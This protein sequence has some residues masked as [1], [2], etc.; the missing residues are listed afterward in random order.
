MSSDDLPPAGAT[1]ANQRSRMVSASLRVG[2]PANRAGRLPEQADPLRECQIDL[3]VDD[4]RAYEYNPRRADNAKFGEIKESIRESGI[5]NPISVTRRPG[6]DHFIVE[7]G[8]NTR[9]LAVQQLWTETRELRFRKLSVLFRPWR[10]E[11]HVLVSHL[12]ENELRGSMTFWDRANGIAALKVQLEVEQGCEL[13]LRQLEAELKQVGIAVSHTTLNYY[14]FTTGRLR[15]LAE[16]VTDLTGLDVI[17]IQPRLNQIK[18]YAQAQAAL[19]EDELYADVLQPVFRRHADTFVQT[20]NFQPEALCRDCEEALALRLN[21]PLMKCRKALDALAAPASDEVAAQDDAADS[22]TDCT[23]EGQT[24]GPIPD[25]NEPR[26]GDTAGSES[27]P[28]TKK[29]EPAA[30]NSIYKDVTS[31]K[32]PA[33]NTIYSE[34]CVGVP[35]KY[36]LP[37]NP[38]ATG[39]DEPG[40]DRRS[41]IVGIERFARLAGVGDCL[42]AAP[43]TPLG[44]TVVALP[45]A[46][47]EALLPRR[48]AW[49]LLALLFGCVDQYLSIVAAH[50]EHAIALDAAMKGAQALDGMDAAEIDMPFLLW[51]F[52]LTDESAA[53]FRQIMALLIAWRVS[54]SDASVQTPRIPS[55]PECD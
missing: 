23:N 34:T 13:S 32:S 20:R 35:G 17:R 18:R 51:L 40:D 37:S 46:N 49:W 38:L 26:V 41:L 19:T 28:E 55:R 30:V 50:P 29:G 1:A 12:I 36:D 33:V 9:L 42:R 39:D 3:D 15:V 53:A 22:S 47:D 24:I 31:R 54:G 5:R 4:I 44:Y 27:E 7:A 10:S 6:E 21:E 11:S 43:A 2:N 16:A 48:R 25:L 45:E 52:D 8:G 14:R